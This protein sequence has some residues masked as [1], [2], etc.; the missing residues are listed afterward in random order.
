MKNW[1]SLIIKGHRIQL[2]NCKVT[3]LKAGALQLVL[4][5]AVII[6]L[7][8]TGLVLFTNSQQ[9]FAAHTNFL[10]QT[11][12]NTNQG[13]YHVLNNIPTVNNPQ[14]LKLEGTNEGS[15]VAKQ[16]YWGIFE[17][18]SIASKIKSHQFNKTALV[19][20]S[21]TDTPFRT[22]LYM[23]ETNKPLVLVGNT[24]ITGAAYLSKMGVKSGNMGGKSFYGQQLI[25]GPKNTS[26]GWPA[27]DKSLVEHLNVLLDSVNYLQ[28]D[29]IE[30]DSKNRFRNSFGNPQKVFF[31]QQ[32]LHL[33]N[34]EFIGHIIIKSGKKIVVEPSTKLV[35]VILIA[36]EIVIENNVSGRFQAIASKRIDV[37]KHC[38]LSYPSTL[39]M[40]K[41]KK[42]SPKNEQSDEILSQII[43]NEHTN[44]QGIV[45]YLD[46]N[47]AMNFHSQILL[48]TNSLIE[49]EVYCNKNIEPKGVIHGTVYAHNFLAAEFGAVYQNHLYNTRIDAN[50]LDINYKGLML[51][52]NK[53]GVVS[54]LY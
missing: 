34:K 17:L 18:L 48:R 26:S 24:E 3:K 52:Q 47:E 6:A 4:F 20:G 25:D 45:A 10:Q 29:F 13:I 43:V 16:S 50:A 9:R 11:I 37:G 19:G 7:L 1:C 42:R 38:D 54:W 5:I 41:S 39:V 14:P 46:E 32:A 40:Y 2:K 30:L 53:K 44:I 15:I 31:T 28:S 12:E 21:L 35:D 22:A 49:G 23:E 51:S 8:L 27:L 33:S 36:P